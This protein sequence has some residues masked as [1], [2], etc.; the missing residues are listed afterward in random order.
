[1]LIQ[2]WTILWTIQ[3]LTV[4][5]ATTPNQ[6]WTPM[7]ALNGTPVS[8][9]VAIAMRAAIHSCNLLRM[10]WLDT[11]A[12]FYGSRWLQMSRDVTNGSE[13]AVWCICWSVRSVVHPLSL[14]CSWMVLRPLCH[15]SLDGIHV[16]GNWDKSRSRISS[17]QSR[18]LSVKCHKYSELWHL[19]AFS[20]FV[21]SFRCCTRSLTAYTGRAGCWLLYP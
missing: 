13:Q 10:V 3:M 20:K 6:A 7:S 15:L 9:A 18:S 1:M 16:A 17:I 2:C 19:E 21:Q 12:P 5:V 4:A 8:V 14:A 11:D